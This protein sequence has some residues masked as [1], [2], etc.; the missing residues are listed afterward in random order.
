MM[1]ELLASAAAPTLADVAF[2]AGLKSSAFIEDVGGRLY[3]SPGSTPSIG[4]P[5]PNES[6]I[7]AWN[8]PDPVTEAAADWPVTGG[9]G[10][11]I[12]S[13]RRGWCCML[14]ALGWT[15]SWFDDGGGGGGTGSWKS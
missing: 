6:S 14:G 8:M 3:M 13:L 10:A 2:T 15:F 9:L 12:L 4:V 1:R 7:G 11:S 5:R